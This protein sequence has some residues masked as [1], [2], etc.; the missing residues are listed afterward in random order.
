[1]QLSHSDPQTPWRVT[2]HHP[3]RGL[4]S[5]G[6]ERAIAEAFE[7]VEGILSIEIS[8]GYLVAEV[9][10]D[11]R[12]ATVEQVRARLAGAGVRKTDQEELEREG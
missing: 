9:T 1:M 5:N 8:H 12:L 6:A 7:G 3:L 11:S 4:A 2:V 10:F